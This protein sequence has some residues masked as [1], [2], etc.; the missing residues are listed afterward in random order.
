MNI[1]NN[2]L[3][4]IHLCDALYN[5]W[6]VTYCITSI[7]VEAHILHTKYSL[8]NVFQHEKHIQSSNST[9]KVYS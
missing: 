6:N 7:L 8:I 1:I 2:L 9:Q 4:F 5:A 3:S